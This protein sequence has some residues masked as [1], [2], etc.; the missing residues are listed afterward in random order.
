MNNDFLKEA[1]QGFSCESSHTFADHSGYFGRGLFAH[2]GH[3]VH[4]SRR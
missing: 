3:F 1:P 2:I 4:A